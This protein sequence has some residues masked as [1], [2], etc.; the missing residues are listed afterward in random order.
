MSTRYSRDQILAVL[1]VLAGCHTAPLTHVSK[2]GPARDANDSA[3]ASKL[4]GNYGLRVCCSAPCATDRDSGA[5]V[6]VI[7]DFHSAFSM[8]GQREIN[9]ARSDSAWR[10]FGSGCYALKRTIVRNAS[11]GGISGGG[12]M[13]WR[14]DPQSARLWFAPV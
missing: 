2:T 13:P 5:L 8:A 6:V 11:L 3:D 4:L 7:V 12:H 1:A 14:Y 9:A 10:I